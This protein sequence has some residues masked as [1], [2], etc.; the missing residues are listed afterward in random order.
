MRMRARTHTRLTPSAAFADTIH[1]QQIRTAAKFVQYYNH[2][3][4]DE[5]QDVWVGAVLMGDFNIAPINGSV[6]DR[7]D[8]FPHSCVRV[9]TRH[10]SRVADA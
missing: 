8:P 10:H 5:S 6:H 9:R 2:K 1:L 4:I 7:L 3:H